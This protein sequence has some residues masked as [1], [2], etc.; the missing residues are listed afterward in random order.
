MYFK[1]YS[2]LL[3]VTITVFCFLTFKNSAVFPGRYEVAQLAETLRYKQEGLGF[4]SQWH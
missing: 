4:G 3:L 1:R 2:T